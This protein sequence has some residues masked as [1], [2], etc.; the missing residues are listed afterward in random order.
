M[1]KEKKYSITRQ[2]FSML[3]SHLSVCFITGFLSVMLLGIS[4]Y[5]IAKLLLCII[6]I[7][8]YFAWM[9]S[10]AYSLAE[11]D[12]RSY[13]PLKPYPLKGLVLSIGVALIVGIMWVLYRLSWHYMPMHENVS[14]PTLIVMILYI[15]ITSPFTF[16]ININGEQAN[17]IGQIISVAVP[18]AITFIGYYC[19]YKKIDLS[20]YTNKFVFE[21]K[22]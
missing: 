16:L 1:G 3:T 7:L 18:V 8:I 19:G 4:K 15:Y 21:K 20:K 5:F 9:F 17:L 13:T 11:S 10:S 6:C 22:K 14:I 12:N 2:I